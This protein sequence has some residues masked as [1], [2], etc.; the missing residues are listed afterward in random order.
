MPG[1]VSSPREPRRRS[2]KTSDLIQVTSS[3]ACLLRSLSTQKPTGR[4]RWWW[5]RPHGLPTTFICS[6]LP[7]LLCLSC[8]RRTG[9]IIQF[10]PRPALP[11]AIVNP[12]YQT[13]HRHT[14]QRNAYQL[15]DARQTESKNTKGERQAV[16]HV[17]DL[18]HA[19]A[20]CQQAIVQMA[21]IV[22]Q[23]RLLMADTIN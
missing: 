22:V 14:H 15:I 8:R 5:D 20:G 16:K 17:T 2:Q 7:C 4:V 1:A 6:W 9:L 18:S 10:D 19:Q 3:N 12:D 21:F 23:R 13:H 11:L